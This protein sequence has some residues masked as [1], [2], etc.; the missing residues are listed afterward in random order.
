VT[1]AIVVTYDSER[2]MRNCLTA[3]ADIPTIVVDNASRDDTVG[4]VRREFPNVT[5]I[6]R[7]DNRGYAV[8][9]NTGCRA[10]G[11]DDVI[12]LNPDVVATSDSIATLEEYL[13]THPT[14]GIAAP[15]LV[16]PDGAIQE[17]ARS[18]PSPLRMLVRRSFLRRTSFGQRI[19]AGFL[20]TDAGLEPRAVDQ[21]IGAAML[22]RRSAIREVGPMDQRIFLYGEDVDWCYRMWAHGWEVHLVPEAQMTHH[23]ERAS[24]R[25]LDLRSSAVRH[26]WAS[27]VKLYAIHPRLLLGR[28]PRGVLV[29]SRTREG[30]PTK[31][32]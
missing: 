3:L 8:A 17:S 7:P 24:R 5:V 9:V 22:V 23:Y 10:A 18:F 32:H 19:L 12:I 29:P 13:G 31:G 11:T 2:W 30:A 20:L 16:Y 15:R 14:V 4:L 27:L 25:S 21:V 28:G 1:T 26:H 6:A